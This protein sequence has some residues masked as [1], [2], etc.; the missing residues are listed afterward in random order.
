MSENILIE[1]MEIEY[2]IIRRKIKNPRME[3]KTGSLVLILPNNYTD[4]KKLIEKHKNWIYN[5]LELIE[6]SKN[7][8]FKLESE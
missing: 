6:K 1:N 3:F 8:L 7:L 5:K 4:H 2:T